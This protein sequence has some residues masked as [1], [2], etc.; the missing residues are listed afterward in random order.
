M[1]APRTAANLPP[2]DPEFSAGASEVLAFGVEGMTCAGCAASVRRALESV[3][4]VTAASVDF[5]SGRALVRGRGLDPSRLTAR[6]DG[7]GF[8]A[9]PEAVD[10]TP[11]E[12]RSRLEREDERRR[13]AWRRRAIVA[14]ACWVPM[15]ALHWS[16]HALGHPAWLDPTLAVAGTL[17]L[18]IVGG[19]FYR[20]A[21]EAAKRRT[22]N[23]DTL[24]SIGATTAWL[25]SMMAVLGRGRGWLEGQPTYFAEMAALLG[26]I[27]LGHWLEARASASAGSAIRELLD[28]QPEFAWRRRED[29]SFEEVP[30][31]SI[32]P[33]DLVQI[34]PGARVSVDGRVVEGASALDESVLTG[35]S[36]PVDRTVGDAV[37]AGAINTTGVLL[38]EATVEGRGTTL[39][40]IARLV[41]ESRA[42]RADIQRL[43]DRISAIFVPVVVSIAV[44]TIL[45]WWVAG[46]PARGA[47]AMVTVL[48]IACPCA[49]GL[50]TPMAVV[51]ATGHAAKRGILVRDAAS[52]ERAGRAT[53]VVFDKTGTLTLGRPEVVSIEPAAGIGAIDL[54]RAAAS[55]E[56]ASE[57]PLAKAIVQAA[58]SRGLRIEAVSSFESMPGQGVRGRVSGR[59][60]EVVRSAEASCEIRVDGVAIGTIDLADEPRPDASAAV[61]ALR[62]LG[63]DV[64]MLSGDRRARAIEIAER[65]GIDSGSV[66][67]ETDPTGKL[68]FI[69]STPRG[70]VMVGDGVN[71]AAALARAEVGLALASGTSVAIESAGIVVPGDRVLAVPETIG[72]A[73]MTL[74]AIRQNLFLA[75]AYNVSMIPIAALG[76]LGIHGPL[77]AAGAMAL[78]DLSVVGN[79]LR[80]RAKLRRGVA[81]PAAAQASDA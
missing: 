42:S 41:Q 64:A 4:G 48:I 52:L 81:Q 17:V 77:I 50:A 9:K 14:I 69:E 40:R 7:A 2:E 30:S 11:Q 56:Q 76:L 78:S 46:D 59:V 67:A 43:A 16:G 35:E 23:M 38:V 73:R 28:L 24:I 20:S 57:H 65:V 32:I 58:Q 27:S 31:A 36:I 72:I 12:L 49:L 8:G 74:V 26:L 60:V 37:V 13:G 33:G 10:E 45:G 51:V 1:N 79:A 47:I 34:R 39:A 22:S 19:G 71:D 63:L 6:I 61:A 54:L 44:L 53:R 15:E 75:F 18:A 29:G 68:A 66:V 5:A 21:W 70:T 55:V 80:L 3:E 62:G 25:F